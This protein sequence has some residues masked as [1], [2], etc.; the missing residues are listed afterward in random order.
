[1]TALLLH[2]SENMIS[3]LKKENSRGPLPPRARDRIAD[4]PRNDCGRV[5]SGNGRRGVE[6]HVRHT[7]V[8]PRS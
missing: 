5:C 3:P 2:S 7:A 6:R 1:M 8:Y 4:Y